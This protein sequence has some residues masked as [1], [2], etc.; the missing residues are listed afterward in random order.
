MELRRHVSHDWMPDFM[1]QE[2]LA[3]TD[4]EHEAKLQEFLIIELEQRLEFEAWCDS[5]CNLACGV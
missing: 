4:A 5:N 3:K 2:R 1:S